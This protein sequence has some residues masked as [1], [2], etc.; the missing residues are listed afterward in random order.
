V[1]FDELERLLLRLTGNSAEALEQQIVSRLKR[2][3]RGQLIAA[4]FADQGI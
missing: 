2:E 1:T 3:F 4:R